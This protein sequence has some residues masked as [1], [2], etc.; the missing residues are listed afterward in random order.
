M[1]KLILTGSCPSAVITLGHSVKVVI[2]GGAVSVGDCLLAAYSG[3][4][5]RVGMHRVDRI[6]Y[7]EPVSLEVHARGGAKP[8]TYGP[9]PDLSITGLLLRSRDGLLARYD[10]LE[11]NWY[12]DRHGS[13]C[14]RIRVLLDGHPESAP[15]RR[16][17]T[18]VS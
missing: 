8:L 11:E 2:V 14:D 5:W 18:A 4:S 12:F 16:R 10:E 13:V 3:G 17:E 15:A 1:P 7:S 9:F 6:S